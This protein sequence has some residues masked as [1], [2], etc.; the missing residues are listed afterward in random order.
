[1]KNRIF[2]VFVGWY[3]IVSVMDAMVYSISGLSIFVGHSEGLR[4]VLTIADAIALLLTYGYL[5]WGWFDSEEH[6]LW[7]Y[8]ATRVVKDEYDHAIRERIKK[9][10]AAGKGYF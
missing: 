1:M 7:R 9:D 10:R 6:K 2:P 4:V 3:S 5:N 8:Y